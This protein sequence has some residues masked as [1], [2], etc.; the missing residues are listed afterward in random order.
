MSTLQFVLGEQLPLIY[1]A[2]IS[3]YS[4]ASKPTGKKFKLYI[5]LFENSDKHSSQ[6]A[7]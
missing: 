7:I 5:V 6:C 1:D 3:I 4:V 2:I